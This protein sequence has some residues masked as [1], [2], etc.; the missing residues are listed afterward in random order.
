MA[1]GGQ[2][3]G[4]DGDEQANHAL[5]TVLPSNRSAR[6]LPQS[7]SGFTAVGCGVGAR[8]FGRPEA[9]RGLKWPCSEAIKMEGRMDL[10]KTVGCSSAWILTSACALAPASKN[11]LS[12][13]FWKEQRAFFQGYLSAGLLRADA[14]PSFRASGSR[15]WPRTGGWGRFWSMGPSPQ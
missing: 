5:T 12:V 15:E 11:S 13:V 2:G 8:A 9:Q 4:E 1:G 3:G 6:S 10:P 7:C 14:R